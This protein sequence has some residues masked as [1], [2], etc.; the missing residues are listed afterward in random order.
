MT[1]EVTVLAWEE[2]LRN[3]LTDVPPE[4]YHGLP[5]LGIEAEDIA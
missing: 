1:A 3:L 5:L 4:V 2:K